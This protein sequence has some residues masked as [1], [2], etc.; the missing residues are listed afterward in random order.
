[1]SR[2]AKKAIVLALFAAIGSASGVYIAHNDPD[3]ITLVGMG[4]VCGTAAFF[5]S[6]WAFR[7]KG[8]LDDS[9]ED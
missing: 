8:V 7:T 4:L 5:F 6:W 3:M 9:R 1:M 2:W